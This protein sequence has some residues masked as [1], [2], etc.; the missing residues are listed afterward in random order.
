MKKYHL[1]SFVI[2]LTFV[3]SSCLTAQYKEYKFE[4]TGKTSGQLTITYKNIISSRLDDEIT[5]Q[6]EAEQDY[7]EL[8]S[9]Y[10]EGSMVEDDFPNA[11]MKSKRL[12]EEDNKLCGEIIIEFD[13]IEDI[14]L[15]KYSKKSPFMFHLPSD[16]TF[17]DSNGE[18]APEFI[19][20]VTWS[21]KF[22]TLDLTVEVDDLSSEYISLL[23]IWKANK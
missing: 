2:L 21:K 1:V 13:N 19:Q 12:F 20:L 3:L 14:N 4:M 17:F 18:K 9:D 16:E 22:K 11:K 23:D 10:M 6:E 8:V 7:A 5:V 15:Y